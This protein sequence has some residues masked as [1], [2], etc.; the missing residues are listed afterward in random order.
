MHPIQQLLGEWYAPYM[1]AIDQEQD[2]YRYS[3]FPLQQ[4][5]SHKETG[6]IDRSE[7]G[8][9]LIQLKPQK[10]AIITLHEIF[11]LLIRDP[12]GITF[13]MAAERIGKAIR[14]CLYSFLLQCRMRP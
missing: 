4:S 14:V 8:P 3:S 12:M 2:A 9:Y 1:D 7:Y 6:Q 5:I 11:Q 10:I 13:V